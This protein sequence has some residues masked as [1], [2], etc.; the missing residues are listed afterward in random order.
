MIQR[1]LCWSSFLFLGISFYNITPSMA[2]LWKCRIYLKF[3]SYL[4]IFCAKEPWAVS[5]NM[6]ICRLLLTLPHFGFHSFFVPFLIYPPRRIL[7]LL[8][9]P[10][11]RMLPHIAIRK[12]IMLFGYCIASTWSKKKGHLADPMPNLDQK[13]LSQSICTHHIVTLHSNANFSP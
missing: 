13:S 4:L 7:A 10:P 9:C 2:K 8:V 5:P 11:W 6:S 12:I 3:L 1:A